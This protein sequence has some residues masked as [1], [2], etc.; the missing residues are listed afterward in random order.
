MPVKKIDFFIT[1]LQFYSVSAAADRS[2]VGYV[3]KL[4]S[5][6]VDHIVYNVK[7]IASISF[8]HNHK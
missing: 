1:V 5:Q 6:L 2:H 8:F 4:R 3:E 7:L